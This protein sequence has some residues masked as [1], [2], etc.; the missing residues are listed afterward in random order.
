VGVTDAAGAAEPASVAR[1]ATGRGGDVTFVIRSLGLGGAERQLIELARGLMTRG[2]T[3]RV[4]AFYPGGELRPDL[5]RAGVPVEDLAKRGRWDLLSFARLVRILRRERAPI[6]HAYLG[7]A[8]LVVAALRPLLACRVVV[9]G[10][11]SADLS[12]NRQDWLSGVIGRLN[13]LLARRADLIICNSGAGMRV[14]AAE[15]YPAARMTVVPNGVDTQRFAPDPDARAR[16]RSE[17]RVEPGEL[18]LGLVGRLDPIKGHEVLLRAM[19]PSAAEARLRVV[20]VGTGPDDYREGLAALA[21]QLGIADRV[22]WAGPRTD[23]PAVYAAMDLLVSASHGEG[24]SNVIAEAMACGVPCVVTDVGD[25]A[26][27][28]GD[29]GWTCPPDDPAAL[30][31]AIGQAVREPAT[32]AERGGAARA[33]IVGTYDTQRLIER[34]AERLTTTLEAKRPRR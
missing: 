5:E 23:M 10:I 12:R 26:D 9:W 14:H 11:R 31:A 22:V 8:N 28:V 7:E 27:I 32:L 13:R 29:V 24:F 2:W 1:T 15:G 30:G 3:V 17:W 33:R 21:T 16:V 34:T 19:A 4:V 6:V 18:V 25:S 20:F